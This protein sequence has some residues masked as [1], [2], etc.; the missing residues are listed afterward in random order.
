MAQN[1][2]KPA[3]AAPFRSKADEYREAGLCECGCGLKANREVDAEVASRV[4]FRDVPIGTQ[5]STAHSHNGNPTYNRERLLAN[6]STPASS[7]AAPGSE[8]D[9]EWMRSLIR[10]RT[11]VKLFTVTETEKDIVC[12]PKDGGAAKATNLIRGKGFI[13]ASRDVASV[14]DYLKS[15]GWPIKKSA[16]A[17]PPRPIDPQPVAGV[18]LV[19]CAECPLTAV[20]GELFC[21][22]CAARRKRQAAA[23]LT[24]QNR[25]GPGCACVYCRSRAG[26]NDGYVRMC[27]DA[28]ALLSGA[29]GRLA[30]WDRREA[31]RET[32]TVKL[33]ALP[34]P[35]E[36]NEWEP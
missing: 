21:V 17:S 29:T 14:L 7:S 6:R 31:P 36:C 26:H 10:S 20:P 19:H 2:P 4:Q 27:V 34:H 1:Q 15:E 22:A 12:V 24:M 9:A 23:V 35:W 25:C 28:S 11:T 5:Y 8:T 13:L 16:A 32:A 18:A 3:E 30:A 33:L